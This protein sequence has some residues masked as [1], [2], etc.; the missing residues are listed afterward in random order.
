MKRKSANKPQ[1]SAVPTG[2]PQIQWIK[3]KSKRQNHKSKRVRTLIRKAI[4]V[5]QMCDLDILIVVKD[6]EFDK[7]I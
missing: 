5:S 6:R 7:I 3:D 2:G 1:S 4:E